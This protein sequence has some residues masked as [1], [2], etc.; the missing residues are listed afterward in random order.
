MQVSNARWEFW[1]AHVVF[2]LL[3][4]FMDGIW[5]DA[6][7]GG[8]DAMVLGWLHFWDRPA[9]FLVHGSL[10]LVQRLVNETLGEHDFGW[11][12]LGALVVGDLGVSADRCVAWFVL[13]SI[14]LLLLLWI[15]WRCGLLNFNHAILA[16]W[17]TCLIDSLTFIDTWSVLVSSNRIYSPTILI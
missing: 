7:G 2:P 6:H 16:E 11:L 10:G 13:V 5:L 4:W 8:G 14:S 17:E 12:G 3:V 15:K 9:I 1:L